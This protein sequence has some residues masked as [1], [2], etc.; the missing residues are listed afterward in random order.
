MNDEL[1]KRVQAGQAAIVEAARSTFAEAELDH[2][3]AI[4]RLTLEFE[5][6]LRHERTPLETRDPRHRTLSSS[7]TS[8]IDWSAMSASWL[9][10]EFRARLSQFEIE[11][12]F[13]V[14]CRLLLDLFELQIVFAGILHD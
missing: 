7:T 3:R 12:R 1:V 13:D 10:E 11:A 9:R 2:L 6:H 4:V 5:D 8:G 14:K